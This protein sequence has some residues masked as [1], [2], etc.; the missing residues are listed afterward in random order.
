MSDN[1]EEDHDEH[2]PPSKRRK[3]GA[4]S[5]VVPVEDQAEDEGDE[6]EEEEEE[7]EDTQEVDASA[8]PNTAGMVIEEEDDLDGF[9]AN[10][11]DIEA[12]YEAAENLKHSRPRRKKKKKKRHKKSRITEDELRLVAEARGERYKPDID[13]DADVL[14]DDDS[15]AGG[16]SD[17]SD[18]APRRK[19]RV[20]V[21][22]FDEE[23]IMGHPSTHAQHAA[24]AHS[25]SDDIDDDDFHDYGDDDSMDDDYADRRRNGRDG[26]HGASRAGRSHANAAAAAGAASG[27][28]EDD[29]VVDDDGGGNHRYAYAYE[30]GQVD[31]LY[32]IFG[33]HVYDFLGIPPTQQ[34]VDDLS[35]EADQEAEQALRETEA[36]REKQKQRLAQ[37]TLD[38]IEKG[39][40]GL[41][42]AQKQRVADIIHRDVPER[43]QA[44]V[45]K[46]DDAQLSAIELAKEVRW[47]LQQS[48]FV[49]AQAES[50]GAI[51]EDDVAQILK[52]LRV[53][54]FDVPFIA[55]YLQD[56]Y[57]N[58][59]KPM[60]IWKMDELDEQYLEIYLRRQN[61]E[62]QCAEL[63]LKLG[64]QIALSTTTQTTSSQTAMYERWLQRVQS[65]ELFLTD[66]ATHEALEA[67]DAFLNI[68]PIRDESAAANDDDAINGSGGAGGAGGRTEVQFPEAPDT[69]DM[70]TDDAIDLVLRFVPTE[71]D[72]AQLE[73]VCAQLTE[74]LAEI[75]D[76]SE[77]QLTDLDVAEL[78]RL[79]EFYVQC[80]HDPDSAADRE[81]NQDDY[82]G[83]EA[84][85]F[86]GAS[87]TDVVELQDTIAQIEKHMHE[88]SEYRVEKARQT[89]IQMRDYTRSQQYFQACVDLMPKHKKTKKATSMIRNGRS[90]AASAA[91]GGGG[92][93]GRSSLR[94]GGGVRSFKF[95]IPRALW[96][97]CEQI[98]Y[99]DALCDNV[100]R[101]GARH[102]MPTSVQNVHVE[103]DE[104]ASLIATICG[105][106]EFAQKYA[107]PKA[108]E[109]DVVYHLA[110]VIGHEPVLKLWVSEQLKENGVISTQPT[111]KGRDLVEWTDEL[112]AVKRLNE[113]PV[114]RFLDESTTNAVVV[115]LVLHPNC[116]GC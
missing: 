100:R 99:T 111:L 82:Q 67:V 51:K 10:E 53:D 43:L 65:A 93:G 4:D 91:D 113:K 74:K 39:L 58:V 15:E 110:R 50:A 112:A 57:S 70:L 32:A 28:Y 36:A 86:M 3:T 1:E 106:D 20:K 73:D 24:G 31:K 35:D 92:G 64:A 52:W 5:Y 7:E 54:H 34:N 9:I 29:F 80:L 76:E 49:G 18:G 23:S 79:R 81:C 45:E 101:F 2:E 46:T 11:D 85:K 21:A 56:E 88:L 16:R 33:K 89:E 96:P 78:G 13:I 59:I 98:G 22:D 87:Q 44:R 14:D 47:I 116:I 71:C 17:D 40:A 41:D 108:V 63:K 84:F 55:T 61:I 94:G 60:D 109:N 37:K 97:I 8:H 103:T 19:L 66:A 48:Y 107:T 75:G 62:R 114:L 38:E 104:L 26:G 90:A 42:A 25:M 102:Y 6:E 72:R 27:T 30:T 105:D 12:E 68:V 95:S 69:S 115:V 77:L 83:E